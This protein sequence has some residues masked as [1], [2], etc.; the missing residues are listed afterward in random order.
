M[1]LKMT[2]S[3]IRTYIIP[4]PFCSV[5]GVLI[6]PDSVDSDTWEFVRLFL[7]STEWFRNRRGQRTFRVSKA[8]RVLANKLIHIDS[9]IHL[10]C[11]YFLY[12]YIVY[13]YSSNSTFIIQN[14][15]YFLST[16]E[17]GIQ[18]PYPC[19]KIMDCWEEMS[20]FPA[21][22]WQPKHHRISCCSSC[23][24]SPLD[25]SSFPKALS[26]TRIQ[27]RALSRVFF[28][29]LVPVSP[30]LNTRVVTFDEEQTEPRNASLCPS[31]YH[32]VSI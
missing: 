6:T 20:C 4:K 1:R 13:W 17:L 31:L 16:A 2:I 23:L 15:L 12:F 8:K 21:S 22:P 26:A 9:S 28:C 32:A 7:L 10:F 11:C 14:N 27:L 25:I 3:G 24:W 19:I 5:L 18:V 30:L 29:L